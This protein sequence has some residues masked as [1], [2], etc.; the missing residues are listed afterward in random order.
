MKIDF[1]DIAIGA[2]IVFLLSIIALFVLA[3][4]LIVWDVNLVSM[5]VIKVIGTVAFFS[6]IVSAIARILD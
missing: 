3:F 1:I 2:G 5:F 6:F 4:F